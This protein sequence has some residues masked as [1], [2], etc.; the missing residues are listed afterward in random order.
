[1]WDE[2]RTVSAALAQADSWG[3]SSQ[4][5]DRERSERQDPTAPAAFHT[6]ACRAHAAGCLP[7]AR[8]QW[9]TGLGCALLYIPHSPLYRML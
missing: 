1:M 5:T 6:A 4:K 7:S 3:V 9:A 2:M 8:V